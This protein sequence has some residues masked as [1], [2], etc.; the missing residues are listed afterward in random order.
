MM[1]RIFT[2]ISCVF[3]SAVL[4]AQTPGSKGELLPNVAP[5]AKDAQSGAKSLGFG[6]APSYT[7]NFVYN[8]YSEVFLRIPEPGMHTVMI[9]DQS[10]TAPNGRFRF[11]DLVPGQK[12]IAVFRNGVLLYKALIP[13]QNNRR[14]VLDYFSGYG[15]YLLQTENLYSNFGGNSYG[16]IWNQMWGNIYQGGSYMGYNP[17]PGYGNP[18]GG[19]YNGGYNNY[20]GYNNGYGN[21]YPPQNGMDGYYGNGIMDPA[22]FQMF[23]RTV[24]S[25]S[26][27]NNKLDAIRTQLNQGGFTAMQ[28]K[29]LLDLFS[30]D[31]KKL[32]AAKL[33]YAK[34]PDKQNYFVTH[35]SFTF[36][37]YVKELNAYTSKN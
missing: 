4:H 12:H 32:E 11:F 16:D 20:N 25:R 36:D 35:T 1:K 14:Y 33:C 27:D 17:Y 34:C 24:A 2:L 26:F 21:P 6:N 10:I 22:T 37:N 28:V 7:W 19:Y 13:L 9:D 23:K 29:E 30:F 31:N 3:I 8:G 5:E 18:Q 15:L